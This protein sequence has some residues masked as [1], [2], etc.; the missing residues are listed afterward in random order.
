MEADREG[1]GTERTGDRRG[2]DR[3]S[4]DRR[5]TDRRTPP[6]PWRR[7]WALVTYGVLGAL[8]VVLLW[9]ALAGDDGPATQGAVVEARPAPPA[10]D[11]TPPPAASEP[12]QDAFRTAD[13]ERLVIEGESARGRRVRTELYCASPDPVALRQGIPNAERA[14]V[15]LRDSTGRV[16]GADCKWGAR[17]DERRQDFLL[18]VPPGLADEFAAAPLT[19][20][21]FV[22]RRR[23]LAEVEWI[24]RSE[25]LSLRTVGVLRRV[26]TPSP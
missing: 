5:R 3:R 23:L 2:V 10:V 11:P 8:A 18:L 13:F 9:N 6:P 1:V 20:D 15:A 25:I 22:R 7:P 16:P 21:A 24:G 14:I 26:L 4:D 17:G 19:T 12:S